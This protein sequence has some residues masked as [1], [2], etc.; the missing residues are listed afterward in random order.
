MDKKCGTPIGT[1]RSIETKMK[2]SLAKKGKKLSKKHKENIGL[3]GK[4]RK[5][6]N[7]GIKQTDVAKK[8]NREKHLGEKNNAWRGGISLGKYSVDWTRTLRIAIRERDEY[9]CKICGEKQGDKT[10][11]V[12]H[13]DYDK[14]NCNTN[15]L[16]TLCD[17]CHKKTNFNR[18]YWIEYLNNKLNY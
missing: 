7:K 9:I 17:R 14:Q 4:G 16:I 2:M 8:I 5:A 6:W 13:I 18:D 3:A 12:H 11:P 1:K 10:H 15:N